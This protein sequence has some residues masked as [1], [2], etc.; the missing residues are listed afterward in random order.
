MLNPAWAYTQ[1]GTWKYGTQASCMR[2]QKQM[3]CRGILKKTMQMWMFL[4]SS[5]T[6]FL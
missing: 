4:H 5:I 3:P 1:A 6:F 2:L